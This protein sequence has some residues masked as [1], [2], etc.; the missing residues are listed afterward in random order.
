MSPVEMPVHAS[1]L[2]AMNVFALISPSIHE[3]AIS[4]DIDDEVYDG[5]VVVFNG[6]IRN[7]AAIAALGGA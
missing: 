1:Q 4:I 7:E 6:E 5:C 2:Y 3:G